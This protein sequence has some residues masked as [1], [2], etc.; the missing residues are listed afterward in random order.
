M[1]KFKEIPNEEKPRERLLLYGKNNL[2][3]EELLMIILKTGTKKLSV[4][5]V[6]NNLLAYLKDIRNLKNIT[7]NKLININGI[8]KV[9]AIELLALVELS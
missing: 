7:Y 9:K 8:G 2:S 5:E 1:T 4:K 3:N 6:S